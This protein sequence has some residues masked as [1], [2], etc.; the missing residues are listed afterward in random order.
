MKKSVSI[1]LIVTMLL[2]MVAMALPT[3]AFAANPGPA[4]DDE[5][6]IGATEP[7]IP[8]VT[9]TEPTVPSLPTPAWGDFLSAFLAEGQTQEQRADALAAEGY[10]KVTDEAG[11]MAIEPNG[12]YVLA[13]NIT[14]TSTEPPVGLRPGQD[15]G[16]V[17]PSG[18]TFDGNGYSVDVST[19]QS[20]FGWASNVTI[21]NLKLVGET[22]ANAFWNSN[23]PLSAGFDNNVTLVNIVS[24]VDI[25]VD[26]ADV[27]HIGGIMSKY[28][29]NGDGYFK[30]LRFTGSIKT[31]GDGA[32]KD[33]AVGGIIGVFNDNC[34]KDKIEFINCVNEGEINAAA[35]GVTGLGGI[36]GDINVSRC[37]VT[38]TDCI[39]AGKLT[40]VTASGNAGAAGILGTMNAPVEVKFDDCHNLE[41]GAIDG[42]SFVG[43]ILGIHLTDADVSNSC[44]DVAI[45]CTNAAPLTGTWRIGGIIGA[46]QANI[47]VDNCMNLA[48]GTFSGSLTDIGGI[49][50]VGLKTKDNAGTIVIKNSVNKANIAKDSGTLGGILGYG[51]LATTIENCI[52]YGNLT[53]NKTN[54]FTAGILAVLENGAA[55]TVKSCQNKGNITVKNHR[56]NGVAGVLAYTGGTNTITYCINNGNVTVTTDGDGVKCGWVGGVVGW[57]KGVCDHNKN[58][59][60]I[61]QTGSQVG[62][63]DGD[64]LGGVAAVLN[65]GSKVT[66]C[67]N[68]GAVSGKLVRHIGGVVGFIYNNGSGAYIKNC[69]N[70]GTVTKTQRQDDGGVGGILGAAANTALIEYCT[71]TAAVTVDGTALGVG[72]ILGHASGSNTTINNCINSGALKTTEY[73]NGSD[74]LGGILG[75]ATG[76]VTV[77]SC[78]NAST[79]TV[80]GSAWGVSGV[81]GYTTGNATVKGCTNQA[82]VT[83]NNT[84]G[85]GGVLGMFMSNQTVT[86]EDCLGDTG[87]VVTIKDKSQGDVGAGGVIGCNYSGSA[88]ITVTVKN[89]VNKSSVVNTTSDYSGGVI[90]S[91]SNLNA[92][93]K[94]EGCVNYANLSVSGN[95]GG[96]AGRIQNAT[97]SKCENHGTV[98]G[99]YTGGI[100]GW[101]K[102]ITCVECVNYAAATVT[103]SADCA[104][105]VSIPQGTNTFKDCVNSAAVTTNGY[106]GGIA[107]QHYEGGTS[108]FE[109]CVNNGAITGNGTGKSFVAGII[110]L[111]DKGDFVNCVNNGTI[112]HNAAD[113][114]SG[115]GGIA[116]SY[117]GGSFTG[118][119]NNGDIVS[120][121]TAAPWT[122][123]MTGWVK[124]NVTNCVNT[125]DITVANCR[126]DGGVG[127]LVGILYNGC[128]IS[129][130]VNTGDITGTG[131]SNKV[132]GIAGYAYS[133]GTIQNCANKGDIKSEAANGRIGGILGGDRVDGNPAVTIKNVVNGGT[134]TSTTYAGGIVGN[135]GGNGACKI[136]NAINAGVVN[137]AT[138]A[139][140][141]AGCVNVE[142]K[143]NVNLATVAT[144]I[145]PAGE[146]LT[147]ENNYYL[148]DAAV[149]GAVG[150]AKNGL[151]INEILAGEDYEAAYLYTMLLQIY[152]DL[153]NNTNMGKYTEGSVATLNTA[154]AAANTFMA[155]T[156]PTLP[157]TALHTEIAEVE[158][159]L[160]EAFH[161]LRDKAK[162][163]DY[164]TEAIEK[165]EDAIKAEKSYTEETWAPFAK[166]LEKAR[167]LL[168]QGSK[169]DAAAVTAAEEE[170]TAATKAL[171]AGGVIRTDK[172]F[173]LLEGSAGEFTL[174]GNITVDAPIANFKGTLNGQG[175][176]ITA[177][178][179]I[180]T[181]VE[182]A[183]IKNVN[184]VIG[185]TA[186]GTANGDVT[187]ENVTVAKANVTGAALFADVLADATVTIKNVKS[188]ANTTAAGLVAAAKGDVTIKNAIVA[189]NAVGAGL[190]GVAA[191]KV[192]VDV[193]IVEGNI[194]GTDAYGLV[195]SA[196]ELKLNKVYYVG[197]LDGTNMGAISKTAAAEGSAKVY[198][199]ALNTKGALVAGSTAAAVIASG[200]VAYEVEPTV[201]VQVIGRDSVPTLGEAYADKS[202]VVTKVDN[203]YQNVVP[204]YT[205][206]AVPELPVAPDTSKVDAVIAQAEA[207]KAAD[208][209]EASWKV[210]ADAVAAAKAGKNDMTV[211]ELSA[212]ASALRKAIAEL[213]KNPVSAPVVLVDYSKLDAIIAEVEA[214]KSADYTADSWAPVAAA[215]EAAKAA[216]TATTQAAV[217][218]AVATLTIAKA[219]IVKAS[220][221]APTVKPDDTDDKPA[222]DKPAATEPAVKDGCGSA[223][224]G[225]AVVL[226]AVVALGAG[227]SFKKKED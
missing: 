184:L 136:T 44:K 155:T 79:G 175:Y 178:N 218:Q 205:A 104:G 12:K 87:A 185:K 90:G 152:I 59:G 193:A 141:I 92:A 113:N 135:F 210:L 82:A 183:T 3:V 46:V 216:K 132:G 198:A 145:A 186:F 163:L 158:K 207:L 18:I 126:G 69:V 202:N 93:S 88:G 116:G 109:G 162:F 89:C 199:W 164:L 140:I 28:Q 39:N 180:F 203:K 81:L 48:T 212:T 215:L 181:A 131:T 86:V 137:G 2:S 7:T 57:A 71:N 115:L 94:V 213:V 72:G 119:V 189:G 196:G 111:N 221:V 16:R 172:D 62:R 27:G 130:S 102:N 11:L 123:G 127:G 177:P 34:G 146:G 112:T 208:Y 17:Y 144:P 173:A 80:E 182:D 25:T 29:G 85:V 206:P 201:L 41:T 91:L 161:G 143:G 99:K 120:N 105:I 31:T 169:A 110:A 209:T 138:A 74:G 160:V 150:T 219:G 20:L 13:A 103:G 6:Q 157:A 211:A 149:E 154:L 68:E 22:K 195:V 214:L 49:V 194:T 98:K 153:A 47:N 60:N 45:G 53:N 190:V 167:A 19:S 77:Q 117:N 166:A 84:H 225:A 176:T 35:G 15:P 4:I 122:G 52:N 32:F 226:A 148:A 10:T 38:F 83:A 129:N 159:N 142:V 192:D 21:R 217:D 43:G 1:I 36:V 42:K 70:K 101:C 24:D 26:V 56:N 76:A 223:I 96:V 50:G 51:E 64:G 106:A 107:A 156:L 204:T 151:E 30:D 55:A 97:V 139:G 227:V 58:T 168:A 179:G 40:M 174:A 95:L 191:G 171:K 118:C 220:A 188:A 78:T 100:L 133:A 128:V 54:N 124:G 66:N 134:V 63:D 75:V 114:D 147:A 23:S 197:T 61:T 108:N 121:G 67:V 222:D 200:E 65:G 165:A 224:T 14:L 33:A 37:T 8:E 170:L 9:V 5:A 187:V 73:K 125:G